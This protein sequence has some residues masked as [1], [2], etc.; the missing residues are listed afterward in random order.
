MDI[1]HV[2]LIKTFPGRDTFKFVQGHV[3]TNESMTIM[4]RAK[5]T[6]DVKQTITS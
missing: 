2:H 5:N 6:A 4:F 3:I 1:D